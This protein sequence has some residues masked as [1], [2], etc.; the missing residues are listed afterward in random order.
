MGRFPSRD[1]DPWDKLIQ[2]QDL[3]IAIQQRYVAAKDSIELVL[4]ASK[5]AIPDSIEKLRVHGKLMRNYRD[6]HDER[7]T[8]S[9]TRSCEDK[10]LKAWIDNVSKA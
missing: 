1:G 10:H 8:F 4:E 2:V 3:V 5:Q 9:P 7:A 6:I